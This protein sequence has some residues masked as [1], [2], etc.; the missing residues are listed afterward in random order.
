MSRRKTMGKGSNQ[1]KKTQARDRAK[2]RAPKEAR[3]QL[4]SN[5]AAMNIKCQICMQ[6]FMKTQN[7]AQLQQHIDGKHHGKGFNECFP[8]FDPE[9]FS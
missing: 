9:T 4:K 1:S 2:E 8:D 6:P 5:V 7:E 3:S